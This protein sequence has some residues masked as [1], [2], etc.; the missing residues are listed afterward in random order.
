MGVPLCRA[1]ALALITTLIAASQVHAATI[2]RFDLNC[3]GDGK[4]WRTTG[5]FSG[6]DIGPWS[7]RFHIDLETGLYC[8]GDC[9]IVK[10]IYRVATDKIDLSEASENPGYWLDRISGVLVKSVLSPRTLSHPMRR[11]VV[12]YDMGQYKATCV[13]GPISI[14]PARAF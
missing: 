3:S 9:Q 2:E 1:V 10:T 13:A 5:K 7:I 6:G 8:E 11:D 4:L 14:G 12:I